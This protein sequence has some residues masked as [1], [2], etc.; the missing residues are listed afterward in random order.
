MKKVF[1]SEYN[2]SVVS[3]LKIILNNQIMKNLQVIIQIIV[4]ISVYYVWI[5]RYFNVEKEFHLFGLSDIIRNLVGASKI[6]LSTLLIA[7][8]WYPELGLI[9]ACGMA[10][11]MIFAQYFHF[12]VKNPLIKYVPSLLLLVLS[13][14]LIFTSLEI[15]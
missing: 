4:S 10:F 8:I 1:I 12:K 14:F 13:V 5:F 2:T 15:I 11:F 6:S 7:G 3:I 9:G